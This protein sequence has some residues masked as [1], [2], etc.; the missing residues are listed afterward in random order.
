M[1]SLGVV[2]MLAVLLLIPSAGAAQWPDDAA[3]L[4]TPGPVI[5]PG[6]QL[7]VELVAFD[8]LYG[9][10]TAQVTYR[11]QGRIYIEDEDGG[12]REGARLR[13]VKRP[14]TPLI[15][16]LGAG[17]VLVVDD[18]FFLGDDSSAG[19]YDVEV[20]VEGVGG[21]RL[22]TLRTCVEYQAVASVSGALQTG[23]ATT[24]GCGFLITGVQRS[25][26]E[27]W[28]DLHG[29]FPENGNYRALILD[30]Q[31]VLGRI[32]SGISAVT[33]TLLYLQ[34]PLLTTLKGRTVDVVVHDLQTNSSATLSGLTL[35][36]VR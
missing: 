15:D 24:D 9:P 33:A 26:G 1:R 7:R 31:T 2:A 27:G 11:Y 14:P 23:G 6:G 18:T 21:Y 5:R 13:T 36:T 4:R 20:A 34:S 19:R 12:Q 32:D 17:Q 29:R 35:S 3:A 10:F 8:Q 16:Q 22:K 28:L 25:E 30:R